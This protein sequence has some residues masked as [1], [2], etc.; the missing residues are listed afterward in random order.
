[1][2][3]H[4]MEMERNVA[5]IDTENHELLRHEK[6]RLIKMPCDLK[7]ILV[8]ANNFNKTFFMLFLI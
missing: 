7:M 6:K 5:N 1:M 3:V 4:N 2:F 8:N